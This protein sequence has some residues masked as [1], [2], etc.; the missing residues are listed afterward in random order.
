MTAGQWQVI[1][2]QLQMIA[3]S[4]ANDCRSIAEYFIC[5][6]ISR[7]FVKMQKLRLIAFAIES[8]P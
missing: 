6:K 7:I 5:N 3:E 2:D 4:I 8:R 1:T